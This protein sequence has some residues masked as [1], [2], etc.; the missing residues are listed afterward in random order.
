[1]QMK[2]EEFFITKEE[3]DLTANSWK[4]IGIYVSKLAAGTYKFTIEKGKRKTPPQHRYYFG[5]V[6]G[7]VKDV[8][9]DCGY[10]EIKTN[11]DAHQVLKQLFLKEPIVNDDGEPL[12]NA[13]GEP[14]YKVGSTKKMS[15]LEMNEYIEDIA[16]WLAEK[17]QAVLPAP[18]EQGKIFS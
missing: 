16:Q 7:F 14:V 6:C 10:N 12:L 18:N 9:R 13:K 2:I 8:L 15:T 17:H 4:R 3:K 1:M 11:E 5:G